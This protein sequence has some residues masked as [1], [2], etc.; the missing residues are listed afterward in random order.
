MNVNAEIWNTPTDHLSNRQPDRPVH[1][2][3]P[4]I[5]QAQA[6]RFQAG[7]NG[8]VTYAVKANPERAVLQNLLAAG[9]SAFDVA[10]PNEIRLL[11]DLAPDATLH[12]N[13]PVRSRDEIQFAYASGVRSFSVDSFREFEK[14]RE[15]VPANGVELSIRI[16]LPIEGAVYDFGSKFGATPEKATQL[17][18]QAADAGF[19]PSMTFHP[20]TQCEDPTAWR[21]YI[22]EAASVAKAAGVQL[23]RL[24]VGGGFPSQMDNHTPDLEKIFDLIDSTVSEAFPTK[25]A[26]VCEPGRAMVASAF[27]HATQIKSINDEG[28]V[29]L[30]DGIY[31][32]LSEFPVLDV[33]REYSVV[34]S[35][36]T[37]RTCRETF[38]TVFGPTCD[39]LDVL[40][41]KMALPRDLSEGDYILFHNMGAYVKGVTT[42]FNGYGDLETVTV[43]DL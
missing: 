32:G 36:T 4:S 28:D 34:A 35:C 3:A 42:D 37:A 14:L 9:I 40:P 30:N 11:R 22:I 5:L 10:S 7:F 33:S 1:Y 15:L 39:S 26:L 8:L 29:Y 19:T 24:N 43:L 23:H 13:N 25:P 17:L 18:R 20:G 6:A 16:K 2:F 31:G 27:T 41:N 12:Y 21:A 38:V